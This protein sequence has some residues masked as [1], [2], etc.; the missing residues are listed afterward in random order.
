MDTLVLF[1][2][3]LRN[4]VVFQNPEG[5]EHLSSTSVSTASSEAWHMS[6]VEV[7]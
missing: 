4:H 7:P 5:F 6:L 2:I 1:L 3:L